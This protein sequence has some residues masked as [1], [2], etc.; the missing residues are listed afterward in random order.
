MCFFCKLLFAINLEAHN[1]VYAVGLI[2]SIYWK[3]G[4]FHIRAQ[5]HFRKHLTP[6]PKVWFILIGENSMVSRSGWIESVTEGNCTRGL[7][8]SQCHQCCLSL[9]NVCVCLQKVP[10]TDEVRRHTKASLS[11]VTVSQNTN[12]ISCSVMITFLVPFISVSNS[13]SQTNSVHTATCH[14]E[15]KYAGVP[16]YREKL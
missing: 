13:G 14:R 2:I 16:E 11:S 8:W 15:R 7:K 12:I 6:S 4:C 10:I 5:D 1:F 3:E 9:W